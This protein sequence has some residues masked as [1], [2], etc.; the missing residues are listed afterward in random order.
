MININEAFSELTT[1]ISKR[2]IIQKDIKIL[3]K[4]I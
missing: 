3:Y 4:N 2:K 1:K